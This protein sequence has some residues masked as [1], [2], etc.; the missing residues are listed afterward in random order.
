M[1]TKKPPA[2][3]MLFGDLEVRMRRLGR[4]TVTV[5]VAVLDGLPA[6]HR[7]Q[8]ERLTEDDWRRLMESRPQ[9]KARAL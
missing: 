8:E 5:T 4:G 6:W 7:A 2:L 9:G 3:T 1:K